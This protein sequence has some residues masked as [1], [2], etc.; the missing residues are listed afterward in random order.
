MLEDK[1]VRGVCNTFYDG[2][3]EEEEAEASVREYARARRK[4]DDKYL[5]GV[6]FREL[7]DVLI[8][9]LTDEN[10]SET[11]STTDGETTGTDDETQSLVSETDDPDVARSPKRSKR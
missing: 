3:Q 8:A 2:Q 1:H 10:E 4:F 6:S 9:L 5:D 11:A 7:C